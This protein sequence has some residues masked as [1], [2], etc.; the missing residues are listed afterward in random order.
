M[1]L[2]RQPDRSPLQ[3]CMAVPF[4]LVMVGIGFVQAVHVHDELAKQP[5]PP[6]HCSLCV[7]AHQAVAVI[8]A[9]SAP[10]PVLDATLIVPVE[11]SC[12]SLLQIG[13]PFSRPPPQ[14]L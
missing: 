6:S 8:S 2:L 4:V 10:V 11:T 9:L 5:T 3:K 14:V 13:V 1:P 12:E 7:V